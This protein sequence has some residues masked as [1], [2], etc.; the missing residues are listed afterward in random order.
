MKRLFG[1]PLSGALAAA[2]AGLSLVA[3]T[4]SVGVPGPAGAAGPPGAAGDIGPAGVRGPPGD[5]GQPGP[6][7]T[8]YSGAQNAT[9]ATTAPG[10]T[11]IDVP[12][13]LTSFSSTANSAIAD[14]LASGSITATGAGPVTGC[15]LR[16]VIDGT[17][18]GDPTYGDRYLSVQ[19]S[20][21][22]AFTLMQRS[23]LVAAGPHN[24][25]VQMARLSA[26]GTGE[27]QI[28]A[29]EYS[30]VRVLISVR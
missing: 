17:A 23:T 20:Q 26:E 9:A 8:A 25:K 22:H 29:G 27:C 30:Q 28:D 12:G 11:W 19:L 4:Q 2:L 18:T 10:S 6:G 14:L 1:G 13:T 21:W 3:C 16:F 24:A 5:A 7:Y 15:S